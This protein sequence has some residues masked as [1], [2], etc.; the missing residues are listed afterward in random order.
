MLCAHPPA[1]ILGLLF[2]TSSGLT[3]PWVNPSLHPNHQMHLVGREG[4]YLPSLPKA[5][6]KFRSLSPLLPSGGQEPPHTHGASG[7]CGLQPQL[8]PGFPEMKLGIKKGG[9]KGIPPCREG[10]C[11]P[12][13][14]K[15]GVFL[16]PWEQRGVLHAPG[17]ESGGSVGQDLAP[18]R[19]ALEGSSCRDY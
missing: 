1:G 9:K 7:T 12:L 3:A 13:D 4:K 18:G 2:L 10:C 11:A 15:Q 8:L 14:L 6:L 19:R 16:Q 5:T 17:W